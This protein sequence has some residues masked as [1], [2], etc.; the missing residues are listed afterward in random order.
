MCALVPFM[1]FAG[2][3][4]VAMPVPV[5]HVYVP[6]GFDSN[7]NT[8][9][10]ITGFLP[11]L[12]YKIPSSQ[13]S[14]GEGKISIAMTALH[15]QSGMGFCADVIIP[16]IEYINV[17]T[18]KAGGYK[19]AINED[20]SNAVNDKITIAPAKSSSIDDAIYANVDS[21]LPSENGSR[22]VQLKGYNPSDCFV[23]KDIVIVDN[24]VDTYSILPRMKQIHTFCPKKLIPFTYEFDVPEKLEAEKI[25]L[26][27]RVMV[28]RAINAFYNNK[29]Q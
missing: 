21:I 13:V 15:T 6:N 16:F 11:N 14:V 3:A 27:V 23:L 28:G 10:V 17:G 26:H 29:P 7:D 4:P 22:T 18:L 25:L 8:E 12:C 24:G 20:S 2:S 19:I 1:S 9:I 5:D